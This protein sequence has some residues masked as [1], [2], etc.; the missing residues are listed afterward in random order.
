MWLTAPIFNTRGPRRPQP[1]SR[2]ISKWNTRVGKTFCHFCSHRSC[3]S[4]WCLAAAAVTSARG[5]FAMTLGGKG[6]S[7]ARFPSDPG[8]AVAV[9]GDARAVDGS[10]ANTSGVAAGRGIIFALDGPARPRTRLCSDE[11]TLTLTRASTARASA[12]LVAPPVALALALAP[13]AGGG[14]GGRPAAVLRFNMSILRIEADVA[15]DLDGSPSLSSF[16]PVGAGKASGAGASRGDIA[17]CRGPRRYGG[18][19]WRGARS[20]RAVVTMDDMDRPIPLRVC[21]RR[22]GGRG[23]HKETAGARETEG[24]R[25]SWMTVCVSLTDGGLLGGWHHRTP[26]G[27]RV[28]RA[29]GQ[30]GGSKFTE[31]TQLSGGVHGVFIHRCRPGGQTKQAACSVSLGGLLL[32]A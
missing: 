8:V 12:A 28:R 19:L 20:V 10:G 2:P 22:G 3:S 23:S 25:E 17:G 6:E 11:E 14:A 30:H 16:K 21:E 9:A 32:H 27:R 7:R 29:R 18:G 24:E 5:R 1:S 13:A 31:H 15:M 4:L 26:K